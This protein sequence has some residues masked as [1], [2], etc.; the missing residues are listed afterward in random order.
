MSVVG[1]R[2]FTPGMDPERYASYLQHRPGANIEMVRNAT[3][4]DG[5][6]MY[7]PARG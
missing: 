7:D 1:P 4:A 3:R 2:R 5:A 6:T